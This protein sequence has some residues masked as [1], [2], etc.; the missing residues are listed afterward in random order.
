MKR[1]IYNSGNRDDNEPAILDLLNKRN[2]K[3][4][5]LRPGDGADLIVWIDPMIAVEVKNPDQP[6]SKRALT[7]SEQDTQAYCQN[8]HIPYYVIE[9]P[10]DMNE[11][12]NI[13]FARLGHG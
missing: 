1:S 3:W 4:T 9:T 8:T 2:I 6:K 12:L 11:I 5:Q 13:Y 10:E 7:E